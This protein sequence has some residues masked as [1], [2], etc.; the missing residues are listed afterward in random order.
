MSD[1]PKIDLDDITRCPASIA[2][3]SCANT[4]D[5][6]HVVTVDSIVGVFCISACNECC[7]DP[8]PTFSPVAAAQRVITHCEH[9]GIDLDQMATAR[10]SEERTS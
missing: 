10:E 6:V 1:Q 2:C 9:L 3:E 5:D 8:L 7:A 4:T